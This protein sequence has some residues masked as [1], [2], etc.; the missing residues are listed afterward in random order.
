M[1]IFNLAS[2]FLF[3]TIPDS[4]N[5]YAAERFLWIKKKTMKKASQRE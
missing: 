1:V 5:F 3:K 4:V 2:P